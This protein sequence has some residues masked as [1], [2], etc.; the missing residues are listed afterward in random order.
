MS[1]LQQ[2]NHKALKI[3]DMTQSKQ[4]NKQIKTSMR[5]RR[6]WAYYTKTF[7]QHFSRCSGELKKDTGKGHENDFKNENINKRQ[8]IQK[9]TKM[10]FWS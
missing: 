5:K 4:Q 6:W 10:K 1:S 8:K 9:E 3:K 7:K 2:K